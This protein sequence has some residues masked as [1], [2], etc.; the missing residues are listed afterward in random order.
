MRIKSLYVWF[1]F[2]STQHTVF[3]RIHI[4]RNRADLAALRGFIREYKKWFAGFEEDN[5]REIHGEYA[6]RINKRHARQAIIRLIGTDRDTI[7]V[8]IPVIPAG[9][10]ALIDSERGR[11]KRWLEKNSLVLQRRPER[12]YLLPPDQASALMEKFR[13][14]KE[15]VADA[16][17]E[18]DRVRSVILEKL[19]ELAE[20]Y[21]LEKAINREKLEEIRFHE[22]R[23]TIVPL[24]ISEAAYRSIG[25]DEEAYRETL[26]EMARE[27]ASGLVEE[28]KEAL[29]RLKRGEKVQRKRLLAK[30]ERTREMARKVGLDIDDAI[31]SL[32]QLV[33]HPELIDEARIRKLDESILARLGW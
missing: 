26:R 9:I 18:L 11:F 3:L 19:M 15:A 12:I 21:G 2:P 13:E 7:E 30:L 1:N 22:P 17:A 10:T 31:D 33:E 28:F 5:I 14:A 23:L 32:R 25:L 16:N 4:P 24:E 27:I 8:L 20:K 6:K 29:L